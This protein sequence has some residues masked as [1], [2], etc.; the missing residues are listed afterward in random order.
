MSPSSLPHHLP[1]PEATTSAILGASSAGWSPIRTANRPILGETANHRDSSTSSSHIDSE[2]GSNGK[3]TPQIPTH[4]ANIAVL[5]S[6]GLVSNSIFKSGVASPTQSQTPPQSDPSRQSPPQGQRHTSDNR[7]GLGLGISASHGSPGKNHVPRNASNSSIGSIQSTSD[8]E[9]EVISPARNMFKASPRKSQGF[10][11]LEKASYVS[12]SPFRKNGSSVDEPQA[13][14]LSLPNNAWAVSAAAAR[15]QPDSPR[16]ERPESIG[17]VPCTPERTPQRLATAIGNGDP[18]FSTPTSQ[19]GTPLG[20]PRGTRSALDSPSKG[21]L[22]VS[23]RLHGPRLM[24]SSSATASPQDSPT[25]RERRKTVTFDEVLDVQEFDRESSFDGS[26]L[27]SASSI[28]SS[29]GG[30]DAA[31]PGVSSSEGGGDDEGM[32][33]EGDASKVVQKLMVVN[34]TP[35]SVSSM[36]STPELDEHNTQ[37]SLDRQA[38]HRP[39]VSSDNID[40]SSNDSRDLSSIDEPRSPPPEEASFEQEHGDKTFNTA[41]DVSFYNDTA[42]ADPESDVSGGNMSA[43]GGLHRV[44]SLVDE[45]LEGDLLGSSIQP[46]EMNASPP[47]RRRAAGP[48]LGE[49][50]E[51]SKPLPLLPPQQLKAPQHAPYELSLPA[52]SPLMNLD[53]AEDATPSTPASQERVSLKEAEEVEVELQVQPQ[54]QQPLPT[55]GIAAKQR[56]SARPHISRE[57]VLQ[58]VAREKLMQDEQQQQHQQGSSPVKTKEDGVPQAKSQSVI[59]VRRSEGGDT[60]SRSGSGAI[61]SSEVV[62]E[63]VRG[64]ALPTLIPSP[65]KQAAHAHLASPLERLSA[66]AAAA[67]QARAALHVEEA[68]T[69]VEMMDTDTESTRRQEC[70]FSES[71]GKHSLFNG[72]SYDTASGLSSPS[73]AGSTPLMLTPAQQA[74]QIIAR[75]RSKNGKAANYRPQPR[76]SLSE[77]ADSHDDGQA[78]EKRSEERSLFPAN[79]NNDAEL[80]E[81]ELLRNRHLLDASLKGAIGSEFESGLEREISRIYRQGEQKYKINDRG[82]YASV[83]EKVTHNSKAGD[84]DSGKAWRRLRRPSDMNEY[85]K[86]MRDYRENENPKKA[87]GKVFVLVD[88]FTPSGLPVPS[89]PT[90]FCCV[91]DNGLHVVKTATA[92]LRPGAVA[93]KIGQEFELIQHRNLE[94]SLTL[95]V[96]RDSHLHEK[97]RTE[98]STATTAK[99]I[100]PS[101]SRGMGK[102]FSSPKKKSAFSASSTNASMATVGGQA[103]AM[104][105]P[106]ISYINK[107]GAFGRCDVVFDKIAQQCLA[108]CLI[109]DLPVHGVNEPA[110]SLSSSLH[111][112][113]S[114][115]FTRN[116]GKVRGTLRLKLF[117]LPPMPSVP[118]DL[119]PQNLGDCI[120]GM[121][122]AKWHNGEAWME[123]TLTQLGG[124]CVSWRRRPVKAQGAHLIGYNEITKKPT[125]KIDLSKAV[126]IEQSHDPVTN[127]KGSYTMDDEEVDETY[128]VERSFRITF[129]DGEKIYFFADTDGEMKKWLDALKKVIG[130]EVIPANCIWATVATDMVKAVMD[131]NSKVVAAPSTPKSKRVAVRT[132]ETSQSRRVPSGVSFQQQQQ[133]QHQQQHQRLSAPPLSSS[134]SSSQ[135]PMPIKARTHSRAHS[136]LSDVLEV[137]T[138]EPTPTRVPQQPMTNRISSS[139]HS[140]APQHTPKSRTSVERPASVY[141]DGRQ[142]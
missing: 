139:H 92:A 130:K 113:A 44:D 41:P 47:R 72:Q 110:P 80:R 82:A 7:M 32:W 112:N 64:T 75:R 63:E 96:Q 16:R 20:T 94:F 43:Y 111:N 127:T 14:P 52:W 114:M 104:V 97:A 39:G 21:G 79:D 87:A 27:Q 62:V 19:Q 117:Y 66:E 31:V 121:E 6:H 15:S 107:E 29:L 124:D 77:G 23:N 101:F 98:I 55:V 100:T 83:D 18:D 33:L 49:Q 50:Q 13:R 126:A 129:K 132:E 91:L 10:K 1:S 28:A 140:A 99:K 142:K 25:K 93:S 125:I 24:E 85:A 45:L 69:A 81:E 136:T 102:L 118:K 76:R 120:R 78:K 46:R 131:R 35:E 4:R 137:A 122:A 109:V 53:L 36:F 141:V 105:E 11:K 8:A 108:R 135:S 40:S 26:S 30:A 86:E 70:W 54:Q 88:S 106:M 67:E 115:D 2:S 22:L 128:H 68:P 58:R 57:E 119:M 116:L 133:Q 60:I 103:Q 56:G 84:V 42:Y 48:T 5:R 95:V 89:K 65:V 90:R 12:N 134:S 38:F 3:G 73:V 34:G 51:K 71:E 74:E 138:P 9:N 17:G 59:T 123:G 37:K 61:V